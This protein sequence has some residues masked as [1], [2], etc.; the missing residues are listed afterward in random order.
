MNSATFTMDR[1]KAILAPVIKESKK[2]K[3]S[4]AANTKA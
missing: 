2:E 4:I 1:T 3:Q